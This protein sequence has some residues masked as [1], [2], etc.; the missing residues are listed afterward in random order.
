M[1]SDIIVLT[2]LGAIIL[3]VSDMRRSIDFYKGLIGLPLK[4]QSL[5]WTEFF[6]GGTTLALHPAKRKDKNKASSAILVGFMVNDL[7]N[8]VKLLKAKGVKFFKEP[9]QEPFGKH[10]IF[11]DPDEHLISIAQ[12]ETKSAEG[13]DLLG[14]IGTE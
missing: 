6:D 7:D 3:L 11:E 1:W 9:R 14:L 8:T 12:L 10:A 13:F 4:Q 5:E 2:R